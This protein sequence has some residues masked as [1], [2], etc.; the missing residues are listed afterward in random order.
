MK[1][2]HSRSETGGIEYRQDGDV[3]EVRSVSGD[4]SSVLH[5]G[6]GSYNSVGDFEFY[7]TTQLNGSV[8]DV[9]RHGNLVKLSQDGKQR[10]FFRNSHVWETK[11]FETADGR[12]T[13][14]INCCRLSQYPGCAR[15]TGGRLNPDVRIE[16]PTH[17]VCPH[18][19]RS[20]SSHSER[21]RRCHSVASMSVFSVPSSDEILS[22]SGLRDSGRMV[23]SAF[24]RGVF[25]LPHD[26]PWS[27]CFNV[28]FAN[29]NYIKTLPTGRVIRDNLRG[30]RK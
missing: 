16:Q 28:R 1:P 4:E 30:D 8:N 2:K 25:R 20:R 7:L 14:P 21:I 10:T 24:P 6:G 9:A 12:K 11:H 19:L 27:M 17:Q 23:S 5:E 29:V 15:Q 26:R 22:Q 18:C 13:A 3:F